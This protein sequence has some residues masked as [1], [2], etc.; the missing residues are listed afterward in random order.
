MLVLSSGSRASAAA[1]AAASA[2]AAAAA[3]AA[4]RTPQSI[5]ASHDAQERKR[6]RME[7][8]QEPRVPRDRK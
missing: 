7:T 8:G 5:A 3:A 6:Q 4:V 1:A 2:A